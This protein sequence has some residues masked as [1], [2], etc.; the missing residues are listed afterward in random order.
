MIISVELSDED[1]GHVCGA[2]DIAADEADTYIASMADEDEDDEIDEQVSESAES[3]RISNYITT[4]V[5]H[6]YERARV[7]FSNN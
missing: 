6:A 3:R 5:Q 7:S 1:W 2:L 4:V